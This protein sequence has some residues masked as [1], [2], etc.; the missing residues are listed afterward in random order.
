MIKPLTFFYYSTISKFDDIFINEISN[1]KDVYLT[2][3]KIN[4]EY[5]NY[6]N[7]LEFIN[8]DDFI[9]KVT[10]YI[11][12][13]KMNRSI[14]FLDIY[15]FTVKYKNDGK[16]YYYLFDGINI[17]INKDNIENIQLNMKTTFSNWN[18]YYPFFE[19][20][21]EIEIRKN[22]SINKYL[23]DDTI[24]KINNFNYYLEDKINK[25][26]SIYE[27]TFGSY[28]VKTFEQT[29]LMVIYWN[30]Y[31]RKLVQFLTLSK[32]ENWKFIYINEDFYNDINLLIQFI[33][34]GGIL[35][36]LDKNIDLLL[37]KQNFNIDFINS[38]FSYLNI[39]LTLTYYDIIKVILN[40]FIFA[41]FWS[42]LWKAKHISIKI[43][44]W[45]QASINYSMKLVYY[46]VYIFWII[47]FL[48]QFEY[49]K[50]LFNK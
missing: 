10:D 5:I 34:Y 49:I 11:N 24:E 42:F 8:I 31:W 13:E 12:F 4:D 14:I 25:F 40:M 26:I 6:I 22:K 45:R 43:K 27:N 28:L 20:N 21:F 37:K 1:K 38:F 30:A 15:Y 46:S 41:I 29:P 23:L 7:S 9:K 50:W 33:F 19:K 35:W 3:I 39:N 16:I 36:V 2:P 44:F 17:N 18:W 48:L 32:D 47:W